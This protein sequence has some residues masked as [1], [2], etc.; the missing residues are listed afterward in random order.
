[1]SVHWSLMITVKKLNLWS[2][3]MYLW[4]WKV[5]WPDFCTSSNSWGTF[6]NSSSTK[7]MDAWF[8][9]SHLRKGPISSI[10]FI[11]YNNSDNCT[12]WGNKELL[13]I[14]SAVSGESVISWCIFKI[15]VKGKS[16]IWTEQEKAVLDKNLGNSSIYVSWILSLL[17]FTASDS[18]EFMNI[19]LS[20]SLKLSICQRKYSG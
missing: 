11:V 18:S 3:L 1:M 6:W 16:T 14:S 5:S 2:L 13:C 9:M 10:L 4:Y 8:W 20:S 15:F 19:F 17:D 7:K 12:T